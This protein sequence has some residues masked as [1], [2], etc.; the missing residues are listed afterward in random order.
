[1]VEATRQCTSALYGTYACPYIHTAKRGGEAFTKGREVE[2]Y[3]RKETTQGNMTQQ[4]TC[5]LLGCS[6]YSFFLDTPCNEGML[7]VLI[8]SSSFHRISLARIGLGHS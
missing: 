2:W 6:L 8:G 7:S 3:K 1:M 5:V 4:Q